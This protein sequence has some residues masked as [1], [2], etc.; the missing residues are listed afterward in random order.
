ML[1]TFSGHDGSGKTRVSQQVA[2]RLG[3][4]WWGMA[5]IT[6]RFAAERGLTMV[7][8]NE[9]LREHPEMDRELDAF[10]A[11]L[12]GREGL[13]VDARAAW[14]FLPE[15]FKVFIT[16]A[17][18]VRAERALKGQRLGEEYASL[19]EAEKLLEKKIRVFQER[20]QDLYGIDVF[21]PENFDVV[22]DSSA[23]TVDAVVERVLDALA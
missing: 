14:H 5:E 3:Y 8:Y 22:I 6:R 9:L 1:I 13:V 16:A 21:D 2:E 19:E 11:S 7:E 4:D 18:Q 12:A 17:P 23:L 15:S 10:V 20:L